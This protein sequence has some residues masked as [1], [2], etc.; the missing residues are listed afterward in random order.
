MGEIPR[1]LFV[2][3]YFDPEKGYISNHLPAELAHKAEVFIL[4]PDSN[5]LRRKLESMCNV[6][7]GNHGNQAWTS[8]LLN[9]KITVILSRNILRKFGVIFKD[10]K[11]ILKFVNP[12]IIQSLVTFPSILNFNLSRYLEP[13]Q[14]LFLQDHSSISVFRYNRRGRV[15]LYLFRKFLSPYILKNTDTVFCPSPDIISVA[16]KYYG[17]PPSKITYQQLGVNHRVFHLPGESDKKS[18]ELLRQT[19]GI[20]NRKVVIYAGRLTRDKGINLLIKSIEMINATSKG[21]LFVLV[22]DGDSDVLLKIRA[23]S[24][25]IHVPAI[26]SDSLNYYYWSSD[27]GVWP[28]EGST[29]ILDALASGLPVVVRK[30]LTEPERRVYHEYM[31]EDDNSIDLTEKILLAIDNPPTLSRRVMESSTLIEKNS[32][33]LIA[34]SRWEIYVGNE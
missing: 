26:P 16:Q 33:S 24:N 13:N 18:V 9:S 25:C 21:I 29:S 30:Q 1:L 10:L 3:D 11:P 7:Y 2:V 28:R 22:G 34:K 19:L 31:F 27:I 20:G 14:R 12:H 8:Y 23:L 32:W 15:F 6:Q 17:V 5:E 4:A